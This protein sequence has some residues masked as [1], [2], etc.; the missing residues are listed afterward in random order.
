MIPKL[1]AWFTGPIG[2]WVVIALVFAG[3]TLFHRVDAA[4]EARAECQLGQIEAALVAEQDRAKR[5]EQIAAQARARAD[6]AQAELAELEI[7][8]NEILEELEDQGPLCDLSDDLRER[9]LGIN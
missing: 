5:A 6:S 3:W 2:K 1:V 8:R 7:A 9:L 4:R